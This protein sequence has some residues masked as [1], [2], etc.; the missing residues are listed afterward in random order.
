MKVL[1]KKATVV[2]PNS[3]WN[4]KQADILIESGKISKIAESIKA[5]ADQV[6]EDTN[7]HVSPGWFDMHANFRDP[8]HEYKE[9]LTTGVE[10][11]IAGGFTGV[12]L[13]PSTEPA[14]SN[15]SAVEYIINKTAHAPVDVLPCGTISEQHKGEQLA[16]MFDM[17]E[18]GAIA[19]TDDKRPLSHSG[20]MSR[21]LLYAKNCDG[22]IMS[23]PFDQ[24]AQQNGQMNEGVTSTMLGLEGIPNL[25]EELQLTRDLYLSE[26]NDARIHFSTISTPRSL[27]LIAEAK[28]GGLE[29]SCDVAIH[30]LV[31]SDDVITDFDSN[32]KV[33]PPLRTEED[34]KELITGLKEGTID[35][36]CSDHTPE[37][38]EHKNLEFEAANFGIIGLET[39]FGLAVTHLSGE[40]TLDELICKISIN[41][42]SI[43]KLDIPVIKEGFE[44]N[45]TLFDPERQWIFEKSDIKSK[46]KNTPFLGCELVGKPLGIY[47][48]SELRLC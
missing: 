28:E 5:S 4:G 27:D 46:S 18:A 42:R 31:L 35:V 36:I 23:F 37:D 32:F 25:A 7:L 9:D 6:V 22:L 1:I 33:M 19:F 13:M 3:E 41:P 34:R 40:L 14:V 38:T 15:K 43:L 11:A 24:T 16:E 2:D 8:G 47:N 45:L 39:L 20:L 44:A 30:N 10:A 21:A 29:V 48:K 26:Y 12:A 17:K